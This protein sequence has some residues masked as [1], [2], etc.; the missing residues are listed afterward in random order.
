MLLLCR[1]YFDA[2]PRRSVEPISRPADWHVLKEEPTY[3]TIVIE[4]WPTKE[5][6]RMRGFVTNT[7]AWLCDEH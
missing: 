4:V 7:D 2:V 3:P 1:R 6:R 5:E